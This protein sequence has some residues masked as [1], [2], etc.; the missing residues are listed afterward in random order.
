MHCLALGRHCCLS[1]QQEGRDL[2]RTLPT[3]PGEAQSVAGGFGDAV[4]HEHP[5]D[6]LRHRRRTFRS[7]PCSGR[8]ARGLSCNGV[9]CA[10]REPP[11]GSTTVSFGSAEFTRNPWPS[12]PSCPTRCDDSRCSV[13]HDLPCK[14]KDVKGAEHVH[15]S[16]AWT[17]PCSASRRGTLIDAPP[18][19]G[20][21]TAGRPTLRCLFR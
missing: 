10:K 7:C 19:I 14:L 21:D 18:P 4:C 2:C 15:S 13:G 9:H 12:C 6:S 5:H 1:G 20:R 11:R 3:T 8:V 16:G 17:A